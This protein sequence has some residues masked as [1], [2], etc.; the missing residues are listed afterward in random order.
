[1]DVDI[2]KTSAVSKGFLFDFSVRAVRLWKCNCSL[3]DL[4][5]LVLLRTVGRHLKVTS[6]PMETLW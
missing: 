3:A 1:M 5:V 4:T 6:A 2:A